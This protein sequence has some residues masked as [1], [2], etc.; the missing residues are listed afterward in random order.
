MK[1]LNAAQIRE[2]DRLSIER[3]PVSS[4]DLMERAAGRAWE[5]IK[6]I[7]TE[8]KSS[9]LVVCGTG[10]N[11]GDG[12]VIAQKAQECNIN[13][14]CI[15]VSSNKSPKGSPDFTINLQR[16]KETGAPLHIAASPSDTIELSPSTII[17]DALF[18]TGISR[19]AEDF[20]E[21]WIKWINA[22]GL[23]VVSIDIP[24]GLFPDDPRTDVP[25]VQAQ[26]TLTFGCMKF[27][28]V[29]PESARFCGFIYCIDI[30]WDAKAVAEQE[31]N[32]HFIQAKDLASILK[33]ID[34]FAYKNTRGHV[35]ICGGSKGMYGA[36]L[37]S[38]KAAF[39]VGAGLVSVHVPQR[40]E[41]II[42][43]SIPD[44]L[45]ISD[46]EA[47]FLSRFPKANKFNS[48]AIGMGMGANSEQVL[49]QAIIEFGGP[50][51]IDADALH[52]LA[53]NPTWMSFLPKGCVLTPHPGEMANLLRSKNFRLK[54]VIDFAAKHMVYINLKGSFS[55]LITPTAKVFF[56]GT[57]TSALA[58]AGTGDVLSG[59]IAGFL[60][61]GY[62]TVESVI[63]G[64][65]LHGLAGQLVEEKLDITSTTASDVI[66]HIGVAIRNLR[67]LQ[68]T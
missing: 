48:I 23:K 60:A 21:D 44:A 51:V 29:V 53:E 64:N 63:L 13:V 62:S 49:K 19:P 61:Q 28:F 1:I 17:V 2:V 14:Q 54:D 3:E 38:A 9:I 52:Y 37:L 34:P 35:L 33:P 59:M 41:T 42:H 43:Q 68:I 11:G 6:T 20:Y 58:V 55:A 26:F 47:N 57:G 5:I 40:A 50:I 66:E 67:S 45:C 30:G 15:V 16:L 27:S 32:Y 18:G 46:E 65:G 25:I 56:N 39:R 4:I 24:S 8:R 12:L 22:S 31:T 7:A 36:P 10:N